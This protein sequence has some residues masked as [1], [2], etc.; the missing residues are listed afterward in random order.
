[1]KPRD[2]LSSYDETVAECAE[3]LCD[4]IARLVPHAQ[5]EVYPGW[6]VVGFSIDGGMKS[7]F[8]GVAPQRNHVNLLFNHGA[9]LPDPEGILEGAGKGIRH[10]KI[11]SV[12]D[13]RAERL[14]RY[15][16]AAAKLALAAMKKPTP[17]KLAGAS[18]AAVEKATGKTWDVWLKLLDAAGAKKMDH[19]A[20]VA[21]LRSKNPQIS[22]W[23]K[24]Q[25]AVGYEQAR[26][27][28]LVHEKPG[29]FEISKSKTVN[30]SA[31]KLYA[32][33]KDARQ[34]TPWLGETGL[35]TRV[36]H[37]NKS[38]RMDWS[39]GKTI[40]EARFYP[41]GP[42]KCSVTVQH[43]KLSTPKQAETMKQLWG[44]KLDRLKE[45]LE[46]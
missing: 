41:K 32:A 24:Q 39:D 26:G 36:A 3:L 31:R 44:V 13:A 29:G 38:L 1:M 17:E 22:D 18:D 23:W 37:E 6:K 14:N 15:I 34:R 45:R 11:R 35:K 2:F 33:F 21:I 30:V 28:R 27:L 12:K 5:R 9:S 46:G 40:F 42:Q 25:I 20:I 43:F 19:A 4:K 10:I 8:A 7:S 16:K